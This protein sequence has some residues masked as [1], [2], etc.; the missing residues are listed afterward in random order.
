MPKS[1]ETPAF[2][3]E[4][5]DCT[6]LGRVVVEF[7]AAI[8]D[9]IQRLPR[10]WLMLFRLP[11]KGACLRQTKVREHPVHIL[12]CNVFR[13]S[14]M[15]IE[16]RN[17]GENRRTCLARQRHVAKMN[18]IERGFANAENQRPLLLKADIGCSLDQLIGE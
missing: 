12:A 1:M 5:E 4:C 8:M 13:R 3:A 2:A 14:R 6:D 18:A 16:R 9:L 10:I 11:L 7:V 15:K 17:N